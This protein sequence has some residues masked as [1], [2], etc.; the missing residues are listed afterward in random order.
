M[1]TTRLEQAKAAHLQARTPA[2]LRAYLI[3]EQQAAQASRPAYPV[4]TRKTA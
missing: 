2:T 4:T 3:A 1:N